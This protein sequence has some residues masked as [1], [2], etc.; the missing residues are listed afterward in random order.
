LTHINR[1]I[2]SVT[3]RAVDIIRTVYCIHGPWCD[4]KN[5][6]CFMCQLWAS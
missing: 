6:C 3:S 4:R 2:L 5:F 1:Q